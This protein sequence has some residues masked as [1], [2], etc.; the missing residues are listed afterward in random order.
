MRRWIGCVLF[1]VWGATTLLALPS[2]PIPWVW[3]GA[4]ATVSLGVWSFVRPRSSRVRM[5]ALSLAAVILALTAF[6]LLL[7]VSAG[8][9]GRETREY[10][11]AG[12]RVQ[13]PVL[14]YHTGLRDTT[15][16]VVRY[17]PMEVY[18]VAYGIDRHGWRRTPANDE[19]TGP[20]GL[21]L[22]CSFTFGEGLNDD[23]TLPHYVAQELGER[24]LNLGFHGWGPHQMLALLQHELEAPA[25]EGDTPRFAVYTGGRFHAARSAG[26]ASWDP[27]GPKFVLEA[28]GTLTHTGTFKPRDAW[29]GPRVLWQLRKSR[30]FRTLVRTPPTGEAEVDLAVAIVCEAARLFEER[31]PGAR[32]YCLWYGSDSD[33]LEGLETAGLRVLRVTDLYPDEH[34]VVM[35]GI[36][37][38]PAAETNRRLAAFV[39]ERIR[40]DRAG[41]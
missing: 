38:H 31:Y 39:A 6:E 34:P 21:F 18:R 11:V 24:C 17:A 23:E 4:V 40:A 8:P 32:F 26:Y 1:V 35:R 27:Y 41:D 22:G 2:L 37:E 12:Y 9:I 14:G 5:L 36:D 13:H 19:A 20:G 25:L 28:D 7:A 33:Y 29:I 3:S 16:A 30:L 15:T 10:A